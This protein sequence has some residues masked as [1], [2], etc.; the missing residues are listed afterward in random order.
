MRQKRSSS[1]WLG[2]ST[3]SWIRTVA[4]FLNTKGGKLLIGVNDAGDI[5]GLETDRFSNNDKILLHI[6]DLLKN[7]IGIPYTQL[8]DT[9]I[10]EIDNKSI[11]YIDCKKSKTPFILKVSADKEY[12][13]IRS[14]PANQKLSLSQTLKHLKIIT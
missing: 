1:L 8:I 3:F 11:I 13:I 9:R 4:A 5:S 12:F 7:Y 6:H 10:V 14:G 2:A